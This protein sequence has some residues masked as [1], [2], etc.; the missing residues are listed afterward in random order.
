MLKLDDFVLNYI[1][2]FLKR[3]VAKMFHSVNCIG[4][5]AVTHILFAF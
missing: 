5:S 4:L 3:Y 1:K 2:E